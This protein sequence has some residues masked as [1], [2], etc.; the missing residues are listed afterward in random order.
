[1]Q[2]EYH[3]TKLVHNQFRQHYKHQNYFYINPALWSVFSDKTVLRMN[4][5]GILRPQKQ[6]KARILTSCH[7]RALCGVTTLLFKEEYFSYLCSIAKN[8]H[9]CKKAM[10]H[11]HSNNMSSW[12]RKTLVTSLIPLSF[13]SSHIYYGLSRLG[14]LC[15]LFRLYT[16]IETLHYRQR[17]IIFPPLFTLN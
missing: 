7:G 17:L 4:I 10:R 13:P 9:E 1:M 8:T 14:A 2:E 15:R 6:P 3:K 12:Q 5:H 11:W 16:H